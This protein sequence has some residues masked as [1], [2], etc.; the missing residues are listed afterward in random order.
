MVSP[1]MHSSQHTYAS[2]FRVFG[3]REKRGIEWKNEGRD[4][5]SAEEEIVGWEGGREGGRETER[6]IEREREE[7]GDASY[8]LNVN[9]FSVFTSLLLFGSHSATTKMHR[10][11]HRYEYA[12]RIFCEVNVYFAFRLFVINAKRQCFCCCILSH[13]S[14]TCFPNHLL[15][16]FGVIVAEYLCPPST[17]VKCITTLENI[18]IAVACFFFRCCS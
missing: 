10:N 12:V 9:H 14:C 8:E 7:G 18:W 17:L 11:V 6:E 2:Q 3:W 15:V 16:F 5:T 4:R 1:L 13:S